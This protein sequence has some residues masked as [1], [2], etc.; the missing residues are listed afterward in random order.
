MK[1]HL[2][3][4]AT[5]WLLILSFAVLPLSCKKELKPLTVDPAFAAYVISFTSGV[6]SNSTKIQVRLVQECKEA[7]PGKELSSNPFSISPGVSGKAVWVD[8]Q[9][10][11]FVPDEKLESGE[12]YTVDFALNDFTQVPSEL[13]TLKFRF[14]VMK[15]NISYEFNGIEP[16]NESDMKLQKI[17]GSFTTADVAD[18]SELE[19]IIE[20]SG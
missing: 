12:I 15:Q 14:Q 19:K 13:K 6:V 11:E 7:V 10:I 8:R 4:R 1:P 16:E 9:T 2:L 3:Y 18:G 17:R 5:Q 20:F